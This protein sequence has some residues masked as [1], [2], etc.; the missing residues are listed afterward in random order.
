M[1]NKLNKLI[2]LLLF[3][4]ASLSI[5]AALGML[6]NFPS[7]DLA[8]DSAGYL[9]LLQGILDGH[10]LQGLSGLSWRTLGYPIFLVVS[11]LG[12]SLTYTVIIQHLLFFLSAFLAYKISYL[13][14]ESKLSSYLIATLNLYNLQYLK[15]C[16]LILTE[17]TA[18]FLTTLIAFIL[19][20]LYKEEKAKNYFYLSLSIGLAILFRPSHQ[21]LILFLIAIAIKTAYF[22]LQGRISSRILFRQL[23]FL[24][25]PAALLI[26]CQMAY[27]YWDCH[28]FSLTNSEWGS[29]TVFAAGGDLIDTNTEPY[30]DVKQAIKNKLDFYNSPNSP[31]IISSH[32]VS[33]RDV[34]YLVWYSNG[35]LP[36][37][38]KMYPDKKWV[39]VI[40]ELGIEGIKNKP[41]VFFSRGISYTWHLLRFSQFSFVDAKRLSYSNSGNYTKSANSPDNKFIQMMHQ[42]Y[43]LYFYICSWMRFLYFYIAYFLFLIILAVKWRCNIFISMLYLMPVLIAI[44]HAT[45]GPIMRYIIYYTP[46]QIILGSIFYLEAGRMLAKY[47]TG[48]NLNKYGT[49][50]K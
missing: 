8:T 30:K 29:R 3:I 25:A 7:G 35:P 1:L 45:Q 50:Q 32:G 44:P 16:H 23:S 17:S 41:L 11:S 36:I 6:K 43:L 14:T 19:V 15:Y 2:Y 40:K 47:S 21:I 10:P 26:L 22:C 38:Q 20:L 27:V 24:I 48:N 39:K 4:L 13:L 9:K 18:T 49:V 37:I 42:V 12:Q 33:Y 28:E 46:L 5:L 31:Y 34:N